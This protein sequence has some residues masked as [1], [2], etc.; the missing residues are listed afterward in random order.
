M[1]KSRPA[2]RCTCWEP[3]NI[4]LC[5]SN[6]MQVFHLLLLANQLSLIDKADHLQTNKTL[7]LA[8]ASQAIPFTE[9][10]CGLRGLVYFYKQVVLLLQLQHPELEDSWY[11]SQL[12]EILINQL[13]YKAPEI[14]FTQPSYMCFNA[15]LDFLV[16]CIPTLVL[17]LLCMSTKSASRVF[18][19]RKLSSHINGIIQP[20][21]YHSL[22]SGLYLE[23]I[24][25]NRLQGMQLPYLG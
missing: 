18:N 23:T 3:P 5:F 20:Q 7:S 6:L 16:L 11:A 19:S 22:N 9:V 21:I 8:L 15:N 25:V 2:C 10:W 13:V 14:L 1:L 17:S 12:I 4:Y 24:P